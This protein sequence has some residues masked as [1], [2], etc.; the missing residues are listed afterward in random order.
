MG[1]FT[2]GISKH[3]YRGEL[4]C[5]FCQSK[6]NRCLGHVTKYRIRYRCRKC[7]LTYQYDI[8]NRTD[9]NPYAAYSSGSKFAQDLRK[10]LGGRTLKGGVK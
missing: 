9:I 7:G 1:I 3:A 4:T 2:P 8:S 6:A 10:M 5:P